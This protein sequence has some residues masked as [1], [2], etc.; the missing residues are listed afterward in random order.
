MSIST[1]NY[2]EHF[3]PKPDLTRI[4]VIPTYNALH[5]MQ[6]KLKS[7]ALSVPSNLWGGTNGCIGLLMTNKKYATLSLFAYI[8]PM[9][10]G[11]LQIPSNATCAASY[12]VKRVYDENLRVFHE[13]RG[14]EQALIRK[15]VALALKNVLPPSIIVP[16]ENLR[17]TYV[18]LLRTSC[19]CTEKSHQ[20]IWTISK[21]KY[22]ICTMT[23]DY[24]WQHFQQY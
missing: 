20:V 18:R 23:H 14:V 10:P 12:E 21:N 19:Q 7:K 5:Q 24:R 11:V 15:V 2:R 9:H 17:D 3:F 6:L 4:L 16:L 13:V 1:V 22:E 8:R